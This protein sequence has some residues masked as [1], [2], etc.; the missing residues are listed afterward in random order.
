MIKEAH[1]N[2]VYLEKNGIILEEKTTQE[3]NNTPL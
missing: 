3:T 2:I 1:T